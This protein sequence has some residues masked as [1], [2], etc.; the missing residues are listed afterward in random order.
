MTEQEESILI[1]GPAWVGDM[2]MAQSLFKVLK[3]KN[4]AAQIDV[5]APAWTEPLLARMPEVRRSIAMP[6]GHGQ[7]GLSAR[8]KL[9]R[10]LRDQQYDRAIVLP[11]SLKSAIVPFA[12]KA[13]RRTGFLGETRWGLLNDIRPLNKRSLPRTVDRFIALGLEPN[14]PMTD[15]IP[16]PRLE[17][18]RD[19]AQRALH[20][21]G[22]V[23]PNKPVLG[24][25][26]GAEYGPSKRWPPE[27]FAEIARAKLDEGWEVWLFGSE[28]DA[29]LTEKIQEKTGGQCLELSGK[30]SLIE[31]VDLMALSK[32]VV[33]NDSGLMHIAAAVGISVIAVYGSSDPGH[34]PPLSN[35]AQI[36]RLDL[37]CSPCFKRVCPLG[38]TH[39]LKELKP[40]TI[41]D[42]YSRLVRL[43]VSR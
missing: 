35:R 19:N 24:L 2:V 17:L 37:D 22:K 7:L 1:V 29:S 39:C 27:N 32:M 38:H 23:I 5:L 6:L 41:L 33:T 4:P 18:D 31:A 36:E 25:C 14:A 21:L 42:A 12:A 28:K 9:G 20:R 11:R 16:F 3:Q 8:W 34:T 30:T 26:P 13:K 15:P 10:S 43:K 40:E